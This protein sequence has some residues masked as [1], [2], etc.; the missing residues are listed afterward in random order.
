LSLTFD[1]ACIPCSPIFLPFN[2][3]YAI[4][5]GIMKKIRLDLGERSYSIHVGAG[6]VK[7]LPDV[8]KRIGGVPPVVL[9][10]DNIVA[11]KTLRIFRP[12][13]AA[14]PNEVIR[15]QVPSA[16]RSKS[17]EV[18]QEAVQKICRKTRTHRP[19]I[20]ALGGGVVG[21]LAG[22]IAATFRRG[23]PLVQVPTTL[24]AQVDSAIGGKVG[25]DLPEAKNLVGAFY[26]PVSVLSDLDLLDSL[27]ARQVRN[28]MAEVIKYGVISSRELFVYLEN[29]MRDLLSLKKKPLEEV[30]KECAAI[31]A[32]TVEK[33]E[34]D[35]K[36][37][38]IA[39]NFG[40]TLG[41]AIEAASGYSKAYNHGE[42]VGLG[43]LIAAD[44]ALKIEMFREKDLARLRDLIKK[45]GLPLKC[46]G[47]NVR[48]ILNA[49]R[50]DKKFITG[51][52]RLVLPRRIG[53]VEVVEDIPRLLIKTVLR[54]YVT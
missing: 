37:I 41:H 15:I 20:I 14:L 6:A 8:L 25:I 42:S 12:V 35:C 38:R 27:P 39:L 33:D 50:Y 48:E 43:M 21:D 40:H 9:I 10:T 1:P 46:R 34:R 5:Y 49:H 51:A 53:S 4:F 26:Q 30:I 23:V 31:K 13:I 29:N 44:I 22:F 7:R 17:L 24:L 52:N 3:L 2:P 36:D 32:R 19:V 11:R 54:K 18:F 45:A 47:V 16:E 28:G